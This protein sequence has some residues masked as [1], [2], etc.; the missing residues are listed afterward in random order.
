MK[1][2]HQPAWISKPSAVFVNQLYGQL[3]AHSLRPNK[4]PLGFWGVLSGQILPWFYLFYFPHYKK[5]AK[6]CSNTN[7]LCQKPSRWGSVSLNNLQG[8]LWTCQEGVVG[9]G[10]HVFEG[11]GCL[12]EWRTEDRGLG[13]PKRN[14]AAGTQCLWTICGGCC[15]CVERV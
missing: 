1:E 4:W 11:V 14:P 9:V 7:L 15:G 10:E 5:S 12:I 6:K 3:A 8:A 13:S 2:Y